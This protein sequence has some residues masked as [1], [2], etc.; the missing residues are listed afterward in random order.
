MPGALLS[1]WTAWNEPNV[2]RITH[3]LARAVVDD[4]KWN[5]PRDSFVGIDELGTAVRR[6]R[7]SKPD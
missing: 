4:V 1:C 6:L 3:H 7:A 2:E 5:D